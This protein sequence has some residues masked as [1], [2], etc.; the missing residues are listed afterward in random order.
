MK[1]STD[2]TLLSPAP[3]Q[4]GNNK[5]G[6]KPKRKKNPNRKVCGAQHTHINNETPFAQEKTEEEEKKKKN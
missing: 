5:S 2:S 4:F 1:R 6:S 3:T